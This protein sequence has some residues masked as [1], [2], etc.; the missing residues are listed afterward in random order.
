M[1][2]TSMLPESKLLLMYRPRRLVATE[3]FTAFD[4]P[5]AHLQFGSVSLSERFELSEGLSERSSLSELEGHTTRLI[6]SSSSSMSAHVLNA[7]N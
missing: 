2:T 1:S 4:L 6:I 5:L 3:G 7:A